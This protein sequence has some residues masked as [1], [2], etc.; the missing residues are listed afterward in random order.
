VKKKRQAAKDR[1]E[2]LARLK[3]VEALAKGVPQLAQKS[4]LSV[5]T[6][7]NYLNQGGEPSRP[8]LLALASAV[9]VS[10]AWLAN[11][12]QPAV[13]ASSASQEPKLIGLPPEYRTVDILNFPPH[14][15]DQNIDYSGPIWVKSSWLSG[16]L[17]FPRSDVNSIRYW[18][19][20]GNSM[21][22]DVSHGDYLFVDTK[23][24]FLSSGLYVIA[25]DGVSYVNYITFKGPD[26]VEVTGPKQENIL[27]VMT[28]G[29]FD[30]KVSLV[31]RVIGKQASTG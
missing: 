20:I 26:R 12:E 24:P 7:R 25:I 3:E 9:G 6:L 10:V 5:T 19:M 27:F 1:S 28:R 11:G 21:Q 13:G 14:H 8:A 30:Q 23:P 29:E 18:V 4:G 31:S 16:L 22:P 15:G 17:P 2:F